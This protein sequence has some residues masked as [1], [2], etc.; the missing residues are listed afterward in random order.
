MT[1]PA[2]VGTKV[3]SYLRVSTVKQGHSG[4]GL[5]AQREAVRRFIGTDRKLVA[6]YVEVESGKNPDRPEL[7]KALTACR[8][9]RATLV[10]AK[11][12]RLSRNA[13]FLLNLRD[14]GVPFIAADFPMANE[15]TSGILAVFAQHEAKMISERTK[16]AL[17]AAKARGVKLGTARNL[18]PEARTRGLKA[19][20]A[21][22]LVR[23][24]H[25]AA[26]LQPVLERLGPMS[27]N[28]MAK[29]LNAE[30]IPAPRGGRWQATT[31]SRL[32]ARLAPK[33]KRAK[34]RKPRRRL[35]AHRSLA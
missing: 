30:D 1:A 5:E 4:L 23:A 10:V 9:Y 7:A 28:A 19:G 3:V 27:H 13:A 8:A 17:A 14:A 2:D 12:D 18:T 16:A 24:D 6:E 33:P 25:R 29:A 11:L 32:M 22:L 20:R 15:L 21:A 26:D 35:A 31:V 34:A